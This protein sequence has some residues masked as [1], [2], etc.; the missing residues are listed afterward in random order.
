M[1]WTAQLTFPSSLVATNLHQ[2]SLAIGSLSKQM[3]CVWIARSQTQ[4]QILDCWTCLEECLI[5]AGLSAKHFH[6][7][8]CVS[9]NAWHNHQLCLRGRQLDLVDFFGIMLPHAVQSLEYTTLRQ[10]LVIFPSVILCPPYNL[11]PLTIIQQLL[12]VIAFLFS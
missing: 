10:M 3:M 2:H 12:K 9:N 5:D 7:L 4:L 8:L 6:C 11:Q 1:K